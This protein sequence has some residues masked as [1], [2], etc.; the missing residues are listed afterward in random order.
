MTSRVTNGIWLLGM[1]PLPGPNSV[2]LYGYRLKNE[3]TWRKAKLLMS[4]NFYCWRIKCY[5]TGIQYWPIAGYNHRFAVTN[6]FLLFEFQCSS[7]TKIILL[8]QDAYSLWTDFHS[9]G[10]WPITRSQRFIKYQSV[11][12]YHSTFSNLKINAD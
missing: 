4:V 11:I 2:T 9:M 3:S 7:T 12:S 10:F 1:R 8:K 5:T 6:S